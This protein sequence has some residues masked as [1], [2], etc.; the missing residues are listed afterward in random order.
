M[1]PVSPGE[2][3]RSENSLAP[4]DSS[5][6]PASPTT[7]VGKP[8]TVAWITLASPLNVVR[9]ED[10]SQADGPYVI[11]PVGFSQL[12][13]TDAV[14]ASNA[15]RFMMP[16]FLTRCF[17][18]ALSREVPRCRQPSGRGAGCLSGKLQLGVRELPAGGCGRN[19]D[20]A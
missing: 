11:G 19:P 7:I 16:S 6:G 5:S 15:M 17:M 18:V 1:P 14:S 8:S 13:S 3:V 2:I 12:T 9:L 10:V 20:A 4:P